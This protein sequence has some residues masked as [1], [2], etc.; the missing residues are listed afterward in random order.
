MVGGTECKTVCMGRCGGCR[1]YLHCLY[2]SLVLCQTTGKEHSPAHQQEIRLKSFLS[3]P[4]PTKTRPSFPHRKSLLLGSFDKPL[5]LIH[6]KG[7]QDEN[8]KHRKLIKLITWTT[9]LSNSMKLG[10]MP[11]RATQDGRVIVESSD[12]MWSTGNGKQLQ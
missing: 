10:A 12:K 11:C 8:H 1:H 5:I 6:Q 7:K 9:A 4:L 2:H 3:K